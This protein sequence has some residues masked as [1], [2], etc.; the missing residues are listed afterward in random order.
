MPEVANRPSPQRIL[1]Q[2]LTNPI[3]HLL[4][5]QPL[6]V[7][8]H[9]LTQ[10]VEYVVTRSQSSIR[11]ATRLHA[12][13]TSHPHITQ[14]GNDV[15]R[16]RILVTPGITYTRPV[17]SP[18]RFRFIH[19]WAQVISSV[20]ICVSSRSRFCAEVKMS[21][22]VTLASEILRAVL[23]AFGSSVTENTPRCCSVYKIPPKVSS[24]LETCT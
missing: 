15:F 16:H 22:P 9:T 19:C 14:S 21:I 17:G 10:N 20:S 23:L 2:I 4:I 1:K 13:R 3:P 18:V 5:S 24:P 8:H 6:V 7:R 12:A 11:P